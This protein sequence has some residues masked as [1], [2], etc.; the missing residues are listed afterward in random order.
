VDLHIGTTINF[1]PIGINSAALEVACGPPGQR[2]KFRKFL[3]TV[4]YLLTPSALLL[5]KMLV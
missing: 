1:V 5:S 2:G 3:L 4:I